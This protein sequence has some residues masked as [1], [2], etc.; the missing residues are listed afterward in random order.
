[1]AKIR[2]IWSHCITWSVWAARM[3]FCNYKKCDCQQLWKKIVLS[4]STE[5]QPPTKDP[6][7]PNKVL[8]V[9]IKKYYSI[10]IWFE[11]SRHSDWLK[12]LSSSQSECLIFFILS[13]RNNTFQGSS[14]FWKKWANHGLFLFIFVFS[15]QYKLRKRVD[16]V[17]GTRTWGGRMEGSDESTELWRHPRYLNVCSSLQENARTT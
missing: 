9:P 4:C 2:Q 12:K 1:M 15:N 11:H 6:I 7:R 13:G 16:G 14:I 17:L 3:K 5:W 10:K 8:F